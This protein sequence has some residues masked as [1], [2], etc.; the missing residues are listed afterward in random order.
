MDLFGDS[1]YMVLCNP[2]Y[3]KRTLLIYLDLLS[4]SSIKFYNFRRSCVSFVKFIPM[5]LI[6]F[7]AIVCKISFLIAFCLWIKCHELFYNFI[8]SSN[9]L[10]FLIGSSSLGLSAKTATYP[11]NDQHFVSYFPIQIPVIFLS[12]GMQ[13]QESQDNVYMA[14]MLSYYIN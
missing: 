14:V 9:L 4:Y 5:F 2:I 1:S 3:K 7:I 11:M 13:Q 12:Y 8:V 6:I 10:N